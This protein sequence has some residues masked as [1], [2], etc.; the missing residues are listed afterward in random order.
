[1]RMT[2]YS[3]FHGMRLKFILFLSLAL[4]AQPLFAQKKTRLNNDWEFLK[5]DLGGIWE[6]V[7]PGKAGDPESVPLWEKVSLP[8]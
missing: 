6:S 4:L 2:N 7:R 3:I 5:Q 8:H 1:M